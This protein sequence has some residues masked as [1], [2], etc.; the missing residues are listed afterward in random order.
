MQTCE[1]HVSS[2]SV[3]YLSKCK[4]LL[5]TMCNSLLSPQYLSNTTA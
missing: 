2:A 4:P 5:Q 3:E 1:A